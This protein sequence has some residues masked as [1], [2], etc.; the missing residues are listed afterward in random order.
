MKS[1]DQVENEINLV[2]ETLFKLINEIPDY[3]VIIP[4]YCF[5]MQ[6]KQF[7]T[8]APFTSPTNV[9]L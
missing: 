2:F 4:I 9:V 7:L 8:Y 1:L 3:K 5:R 6:R